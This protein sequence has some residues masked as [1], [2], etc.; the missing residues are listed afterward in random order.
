[1][2]KNVD[3]EVYNMKKR[4]YITNDGVNKKIKNI[5]KIEIQPPYINKTYINN[6]NCIDYNL[7]KLFDPEYIFTTEIEF[8]NPNHLKFK[9]NMHIGQ[10]QNS[11]FDILHIY[12][13][14][15]EQFTKCI[16]FLH[17]REINRNIYNLYVT[18]YNLFYKK[19]LNKNINK[20][21]KNIYNL[22]NKID[23]NS[24]YINIDFDLV[25]LLK[26]HL[27]YGVYYTIFNNSKL[28][29]NCIFYGRKFTLY[30][31]N[32]EKYY[33][34]RIEYFIYYPNNNYKFYE[35]QCN[36]FYYNHDNIEDY[37]NLLNKQI[38]PNIN[39]WIK[40]MLLLNI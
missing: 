20:S 13:L 39:N 32:T 9:T 18:K 21:L 24:L 5:K 3:I 40:K 16:I 4:L 26:K 6:L 35:S 33:N 2:V 23:F 30:V 29:I 34:V 27:S 1:M 22:E 37:I 17:G 31:H 7:I 25:K 14:H 10:F 8:L 15:K 11:S 38:Q 28:R 19:Y 36:P 12:D